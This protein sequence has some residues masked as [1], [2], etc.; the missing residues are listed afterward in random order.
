M[1]K[2]IKK[3]IDAIILPDSNVKVQITDLLLA[4]CVDSVELRLVVNH[5]RGNFHFELASRYLNS[6][7]HETRFTWK[8]SLVQKNCEQGKKSNY[9]TVQK[10]A[11]LLITRQLSQRVR[12]EQELGQFSDKPKQIFIIEGQLP[13]FLDD[14]PFN[15]SFND[16]VNDLVN[17]C[18]SFF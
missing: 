16:L 9:E 14:S 4:I 6:L 18:D 17:F 5:I 8:F 10:N 3:I 12:V 11:I 13:F 1:R 7:L 15:N 2:E